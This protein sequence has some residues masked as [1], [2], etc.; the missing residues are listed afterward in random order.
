MVLAASTT[1]TCAHMKALVLF[2][3]RGRGHPTIKK[4]ILHGKGRNLKYQAI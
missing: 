3:S 1:I 4:Y 2:Q